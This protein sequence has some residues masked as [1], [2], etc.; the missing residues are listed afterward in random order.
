MMRCDHCQGRFGLTRYHHFRR[1]FC[2]K[3]CKSA[4]YAKWDDE[5]EKVRRWLGYL[6]RAPTT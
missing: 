4:F 6:S 2:S 1:S 3:S 5:R